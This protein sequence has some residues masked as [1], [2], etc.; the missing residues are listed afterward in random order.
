MIKIVTLKQIKMKSQ[1]HQHQYPA[2]IKAIGLN[3]HN[4]LQEVATVLKRQARFLESNLQHQILLQHMQ[5]QLN[6][7]GSHM[8]NHL[9]NF[10]VIQKMTI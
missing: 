2:D 1:P 5:M 8:Q 4:L 10:Q 7:H 3:F 9:Q 6:W